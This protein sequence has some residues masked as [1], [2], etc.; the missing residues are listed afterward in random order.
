MPKSSMAI[1]T[2]SAFKQGQPANGVLDVVHQGGLGEFQDAEG[3]SKPL[4]VRASLTSV[5]IWSRSS[6]LAETLIETVTRWPWRCQ[7]APCRQA[8]SSTHRPTGTIRP[9]ASRAGMKS[10]GWIT[11]RVG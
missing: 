6:C 5:T 9:L 4:S 1:R 10:S 8:S 7:A 3:G 11:P 2:P